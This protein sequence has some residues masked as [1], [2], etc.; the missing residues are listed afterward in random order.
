MVVV[1][2]AKKFMK[3]EMKPIIEELELK[4]NLDPDALLSLKENNKYLNA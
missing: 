3:P 2:N 1:S 4:V